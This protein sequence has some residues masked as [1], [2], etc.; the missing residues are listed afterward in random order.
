MKRP[1]FTV[2]ELLITIVIITVIMLLAVAGFR[3]T[4][5]A[6]RND[7]RAAKAE[8]IARGLESYYSHGDSARSVPPGQYPSVHAFNQAISSGYID[9]WLPGVEASTLRFSWQDDGAINIQAYGNNALN[10]NLS[11]IT[12]VARSSGQI[13]Y[14]PMKVDFNTGGLDNDRWSACRL[15]ADVCTRFNLYYVPEG[16]SSVQIIRSSQG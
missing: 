13:L 11:L 6:A 2:V 1:G 15:A 9:T 10:E 14:E 5:V 12:P 16:E 3:S 7:E 4:Q 8:T